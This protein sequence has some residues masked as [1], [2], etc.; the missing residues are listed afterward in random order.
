[1]VMKTDASVVI[2]LDLPTYAAKVNLPR[3][4]LVE[5]TRKKSR[6]GTAAS[7]GLVVLV[8]YLRY[9]PNL[10]PIGIIHIGNGSLVDPVAGREHER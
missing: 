7:S 8:I 1:M 4:S 5:G 9:D 3:P 6:P 2:G 10:Y